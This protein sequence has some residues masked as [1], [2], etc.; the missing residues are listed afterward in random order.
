MENNT[1]PM[2]PK[3]YIMNHFLSIIFCAV[4]V[5]SCETNISKTDFEKN[6]ELAKDYF[7]QFENKKTSEVLAYLHPDIEWHLPVYGM[8]MGGFEEVKAA[9]NGYHSEYE[10][11]KFTADYWLPGVNTETG[12]PD[13]STRVYGTWTSTHKRT[14]K[15][16]NLS[17]YHSFEFKDGK[18]IRGGDWFDLGG[19]MN[20]LEPQAISKGGLIGFHNLNVTLNKGYTMEDFL[21]FFKNEVVPAYNA[22][23]M[24]A[25]VHLVK[26]S[27][28]KDVNA[29]GMIWIFES[30][31]FLSKLW[32]EDGTSTELNSKINDQLIEVNEG[33]S[34]I[35]S[36]T[37]EFSDW[38]VQ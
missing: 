26:G 11:L 14:G 37:S 15:R 17:S 24:G 10:D 2:K 20:S 4:L 31:D 35:G 19:M 21:N 5:V 30:E 16:T 36:W 32:N 18:I 6:T 29:I 13:G 7:K 23:Y 8:E 25:R 33:L 3:K 34:K 22:A 27:K 28:G 12:L 1:H 9:I 38:I